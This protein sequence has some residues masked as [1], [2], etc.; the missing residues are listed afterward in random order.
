MKQA[1]IIPCMEIIDIQA[2][3]YICDKKVNLGGSGN[4]QNESGD[5]GGP[6]GDEAK[7]NF[8]SSGIS[9]QFPHYSPWDD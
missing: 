3:G 2:R 4:V 5:S 1:Y 6:D 7:E 8:I 9:G